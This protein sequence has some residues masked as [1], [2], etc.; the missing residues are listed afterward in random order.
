MNAVL[1]A[2]AAIGA[3][4][5]AMRLTGPVSTAGPRRRR[6]WFAR[7]VLG[8]MLAMVVAVPIVLCLVLVALRPSDASLR[9]VHGC[10]TLGFW[11]AAT[12]LALDVIAGSGP[13]RGAA[14]AGAAIAGSAAVIVTSYDRFAVAFPGSWVVLAAATAV[15]LLC[16][17]V[18]S[19]LRRLRRPLA[20]DPAGTV[21][22][23]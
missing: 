9:F 14:M 7:R 19:A 8:A 12:L 11:M 5:A 15:L 3:S 10:L 16:V 22:T 13:R 6:A 20:P 23:G 4:L 18:S 21:A 2:L 1:L 17:S